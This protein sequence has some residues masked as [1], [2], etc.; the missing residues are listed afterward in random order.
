MQERLD[1]F[2]DLRDIEKILGSRNRK[3]RE[4]MEMDAQMDNNKFQKGLKNYLKQNTS[5]GKGGHNRTNNSR[6][7]NNSKKGN[8]SFKDKN[9]NNKNDRGNKT[10]G[11]GGKKRDQKSN[12]KN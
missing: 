4:E 10:G 12:F 11:F 7:Y 3:D 5:G 8:S 6:D 1:Q 9:Y 2:D